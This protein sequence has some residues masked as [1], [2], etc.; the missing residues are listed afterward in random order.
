MKLQQLRTSVRLALNTCATCSL[1]FVITS[2]VCS[3]AYA[4]DPIP[5]LGDN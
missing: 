5:T 1:A 4:D 3:V 2:S